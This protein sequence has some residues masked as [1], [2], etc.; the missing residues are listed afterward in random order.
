MT[1]LFV[2]IFTHFWKSRPFIQSKS[3]LKKTIILKL[4]ELES[5]F[6]HSAPIWYMSD[7]GIHWTC[8]IHL[9]HIRYNDKSYY[10]EYSNIFI[11]YTHWV[12][13][14]DHYYQFIYVFISILSS[15]TNLFAPKIFR[16][17]F[18]PHPLS[19]F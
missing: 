13:C 17:I 3:P 2:K 16:Q 12:Q 18:G 11:I 4:C 14:L 10:F 5:L 7:R 1:C 19:K 6:T 9:L 15:I 8:F